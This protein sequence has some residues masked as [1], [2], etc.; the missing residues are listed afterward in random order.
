MLTIWPVILQV[1]R[2]DHGPE[3]QHADAVDV[4]ELLGRH[5]Y[6]QR[7][8][9]NAG[10]KK[11]RRVLDILAAFDI[12][13]SNV[14]ADQSALYHWQM[15][16]RLDHPT[17]WGT[18]WE[19]LRGLWD[20]IAD[21]L[22]SDETLVIYV[23]NLSY[24]F[25]FL[26]NAY[27]EIDAD[28][29]FALSSRKVAKCTLYE[30]K[31]ELR[32]SY[33]L[34]NMGLGAWTRKMD[35]DHAKC[36]ADT[37]DHQ[38]IR[39]P[40]SELTPEELDYCRNDVVGLLEALQIQL[41]LHGDTLATVPLTSTGYVR[42]DVKRVMAN[43]SKH[44]L[45]ALQPDHET[46]VLL[47]EAF[48]GGNTHANRYY[49]G[50]ILE[51]VGSMD[52]SSSYPDVLINHQFPMRPFKPVA[53]RTPA[54]I[55]RQRGRGYALLLRVGFA[56]L[57]LR[58]PFCGCP[59]ISHSK[60][61]RCAAR[62]CCLDNGR[63]LWA[64]YA[65]MTITDIDWQI[66]AN[67]YVWDHMEILDARASRYGW[68]PDLLVQLII[69]YYR[70]KTELKGVEGQ[71]LYYGKAKALLNSI[72]GLEAQDPCKLDVIFDGVRFHRGDEDIDGKL[73]RAAQHPYGGYQL[74]VWTTAW[75]R[76]ELQRAIDAAGDQ[77]V[78]ADTDSVKFVGQLDLSDY[79]RE[80]VQD[81]DW[82]GACAVDPSGEIHYMG[83]FEDEGRYNRFVTLGAK[84]YAY[85]DKRGLHLTVAGVG[86]KAGAAELQQ[87][88][89]L[90]AFRGGFTF[91]GPAGG[92]RAAYN[93][94]ANI[95]IQLE[96]HPL[97]IGP[98]ICLTP[99]TYTLGIT[100][101]YRRI[102]EDPALFEALA[103]DYHISNADER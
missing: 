60:T 27:L 10:T 54:D 61:R 39:Y 29:V 90:E 42:R 99:T 51:D 98:N 57:R 103:H 73:A 18:S 102:L 16:I 15:Q 5:C 44:G 3:W 100:E 9:G 40:W 35:V 70:A 22:R 47:R 89:G 41:Q 94:E 26:R 78:Y 30:R 93:D 65:E 81:S 77:F 63:I 84:K 12:E 49:A 53:C 50:Q 2:A 17:I 13:T 72:Y 76:Y 64:P 66:I 19:E 74:G 91:S 62:S 4:R 28:Q 48:R 52:R 32:C 58:D 46:Y 75:A 20:R 25:A 37:Y 45:A 11:P 56:N 36:S 79:N 34:T 96:G 6:A 86:K 69:S 97:H 23:H 55:Q 101:D 82:H 14:L 95:D 87:A 7:P 67:Q 85:E 1:A 33:V 71:E 21:E 31:I 88:G 43:W 59:Y 80:K 68:L 92:L 8:P 38:R 83:V 24:E